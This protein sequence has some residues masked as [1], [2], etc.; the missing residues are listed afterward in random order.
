MTFLRKLL[1]SLGFRLAFGFALIAAISAAGTGAATTWSARDNILRAEQDRLINEFSR[2]L[3]GFPNQIDVVNKSRNET[4]TAYVLATLTYSLRGPMGI[5]TPSTGES[6]GNITPGGLPGDFRSGNVSSDFPRFARTTLFGSLYFIVA[7]TK[8]IQL[9][10]GGRVVQTIPIMLYAQNSLI[11]QEQQIN[12]LTTQT[13]LLTVSVGIL[14]AFIG[15]LL[16]R[17]ILRPVTALRRAV[18]RFGQSPNPIRLKASG[19]RELGG[20]IDTFNNTSG[21]LHQT[22]AELTESEKRA[23]RFVADVS[24]ELRTPT[25]AMVA[26]ADTLDNPGAAADQLAEAGRVTASAARRLAKLTE[27]LLEI[28]RFDAG[29]IALQPVNFD[30]AERLG[31]LVS[32]RGWHDV[33]VTATG[34]LRVEL[35]ARRYDVIVSNM[36]ANALTHGGA[37]VEVSASITENRLRVLVADHGPGISAEDL[38]LLFD[39][40]F[41][42]DQSRSRGGTGLGLALVAENAA[43]LGGEVWVESVAGQTTFCVELPLEPDP[44]W[45]VPQRLPT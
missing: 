12:G 17:Q 38:P 5:E 10:S 21:Q 13:A 6:I 41:K 1:G 30:A 33:A 11:L 34:A 15:V 19:V 4:N 36:I 40:F 43:L 20:V 16:S 9:T 24:H 42:S 39:R 35:D 8:D 37:P 44:D 28:S 14:A 25:A 32:D 45:V 27:D 18:E 26:A 7:Q 29:Q 31:L 2:T 23:R 22:M 3:T